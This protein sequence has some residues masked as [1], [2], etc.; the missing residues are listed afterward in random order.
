[1]TESRRSRRQ[2]LTAGVAVGTLLMAGPTAL[3]GCTSSAPPVHDE[4]DPL[5]GPAQRAEHDVAL[6][7]AVAG[8]Q[9]TLE[10]RAVALA[11][12]RQAHATALRGELRRVRPSP[13]PVSA[14]PPTTPV[15]VTADQAVAPD[16]LA[17]AMRAA[18]DEAAGLVMLLPGY[19]AALLASVAACC[20]SHAALLA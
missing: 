20:A 17:G 10:A 11:A 8:A 6:A 19:R 13:A 18:Q 15:M 5:E 1:M 14:T 2:M 16:A 9:P 3:A 7:L 4:P 12:D